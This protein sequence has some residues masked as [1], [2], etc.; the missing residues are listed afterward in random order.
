[1]QDATDILDT[2]EPQAAY[3]ERAFALA[4]V[5]LDHAGELYTRDE[6]IEALLAEADCT[7]EEAANILASLTGDRVDP[8]VA[9]TTPD[10]RYIGVIEYEE[11]AGWYGYTDYHDHFGER[12]RV[13]CAQCVH[14]AAAD[15]EVVHATAGDPGGSFADHPD[16]TYGQLADAIHDHYARAHPDTDPTEVDVEVGASL[17][18]GT[19]IGGN[20]AWHSGNDGAGSG[21]A[22][23]TVDGFQG[24]DLLAKAGGTLTGPLTVNA[25]LDT[26]QTNGAV[27]LPVG[28][29]KWA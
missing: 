4:S 6:A 14:D 21:L 12:K 1:M 5:F 19:T 17:L 28:T 7:T 18:S 20:S 27:V 29:D 8:V 13:V 9:V 22:A 10:A 16:A 23:D 25:V 26:N 24:A 11:G 2:A 15:H 3:H